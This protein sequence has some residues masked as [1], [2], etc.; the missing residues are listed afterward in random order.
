MDNPVRILPSLYLRESSRKRLSPRRPSAAGDLD[1]R[2]SSANLAM[3][4]WRAAFRGL[5]QAGPAQG[6]GLT[7]ARKLIR[8]NRNRILIRDFDL[9][10]LSVLCEC[11]RSLGRV[12][13]GIS[14]VS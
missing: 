12:M 7:D 9:L 3:Q 13:L 4:A 1:P 5:K 8:C 10:W 6:R 14:A 2:P 11:L